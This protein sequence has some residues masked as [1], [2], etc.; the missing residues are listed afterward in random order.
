MWSYHDELLQDAG[1]NPYRKKN[2]LSE[3]F[4]HYRPADYREILSGIDRS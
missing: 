3:W 2:R 1:I 4:S